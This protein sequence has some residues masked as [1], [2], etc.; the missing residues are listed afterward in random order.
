SE[1]TGVTVSDVFFAFKQGMSRQDAMRLADQA[2]AVKAMAD[3]GEPFDALARR[4]SQ[5]PGAERGGQIGTF[6]RGG[7]APL[8]ARSLSAT[9]AGGV[10]PPLPSGNGIHLFRVDAEQTGGHVE[11]DAV[12]D[13]IRQRLAGEALDQRF[14]D[15]IAKNLRERHHVEVLN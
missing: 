1:R 7:M 14:R 11:F 6:K 10:G 4:Y 8:R 5:G 15:W 3:A 13:E 2:K 12:K 9:P